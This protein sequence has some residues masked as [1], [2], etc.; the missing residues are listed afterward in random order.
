MY[1]PP[2]WTESK[3]SDQTLELYFNLCEV[4]SVCGV[5]E[6]RDL[7]EVKACK[8]AAMELKFLKCRFSFRED[9]VS[10]FSIAW[11]YSG[12]ILASPSATI[13]PGKQTED[14]WNW[15]CAKP[16]S[17]ESPHQGKREYTKIREYTK[18]KQFS[19]SRRTSL[20]CEGSWCNC[21]FKRHNMIFIMSTGSLMAV[22]HSSHSLILTNW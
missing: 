10:Q 18:T 5:Q 4:A 14:T 11:C 21:L 20:S 17:H 22:F 13:N 12:S 16:V 15:V 9:G 2:Q 8:V 1:S 6:D 3:G 7:E 19:L